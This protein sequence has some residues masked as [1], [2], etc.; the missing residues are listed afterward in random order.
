MRITKNQLKQIIKEELG[1]VLEAETKYKFRGQEVGVVGDD[2]ETQAA[3]AASDA[4][5]AA[6]KAAAEKAAAEKADRPQG[7]DRLKDTA[8]HYAGKVGLEETKV[9]ESR[10]RKAR[11]VRRK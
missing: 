7:W 3:I 11:K 1:K 2:D 4:K 5:I 8:K 10:R 6:E 9:D